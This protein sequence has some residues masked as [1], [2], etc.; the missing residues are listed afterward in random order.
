ME[1]MALRSQVVEPRSMEE[2]M[3]GKCTAELPG[4]LVQRAVL[5][6]RDGRPVH[7]SAVP[8]ELPDESATD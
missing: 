8:A 1:V 7:S 5:T 6:L 4:P 2:V 3:G